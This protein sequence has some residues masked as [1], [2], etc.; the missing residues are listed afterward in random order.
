M[1]SMTLL[2]AC[3]GVLER[4]LDLVA[5]TLN[6]TNNADGD[7]SRD[8]GIFNSRSSGLAGCK[9]GQRLPD[10][11]LHAHSPQYRIATCNSYETSH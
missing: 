2:K 11:N 6:G 8:Q 5:N 3:F 9:S 4:H 7:K 10:L 1:Q